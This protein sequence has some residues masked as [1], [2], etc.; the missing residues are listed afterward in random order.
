MKASQDKVRHLQEQLRE[1]L[2][3][4]SHLQQSLKLLSLEMEGWRHGTQALKGRKDAL[5]RSN[6]HTQ[7]L[8]DD[9]RSQLKSLVEE[10]T[11]GS[12]AEDQ[13]FA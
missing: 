7:R 3:E 4:N 10:V 12:R 5:E 9:K 6:A 13:T 8:L 2:N 1:G 11:R